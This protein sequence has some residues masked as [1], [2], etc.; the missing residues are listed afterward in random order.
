MAAHGK[1]G[2]RCDGCGKISMN[3]T[4]EYVRKDGSAGYINSEEQDGAKAF[5]TDC[6]QAGRDEKP[7][8]ELQ[9]KHIEHIVV[10]YCTH[11]D[12]RITCDVD[13]RDEVPEIPTHV[14]YNGGLYVEVGAPARVVVECGKHPR[15]STYT[16]VTYG[17]EG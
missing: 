8:F 9:R 13:C 2:R 6:R 15:K 7:A 1:K 10:T 3:R 11:P 4:G 14:T 17:E 12:G 16:T 5:C